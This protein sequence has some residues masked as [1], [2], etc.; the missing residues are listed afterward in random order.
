LTIEDNM[1]EPEQKRKRNH[2]LYSL[3]VNQITCALSNV[4]DYG[5]L[6]MWKTYLRLKSEGK[7]P[8]EFASIV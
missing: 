8:L 3:G 4:R 2:V 7:S 5:D 6:Q 1:S